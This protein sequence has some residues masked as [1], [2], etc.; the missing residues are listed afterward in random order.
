VLEYRAGPL[1]ILFVARRSL[2]NALAYGIPPAPLE[3]QGTTFAKLHTLGIMWTLLLD[4]LFLAYFLTSCY[5]QTSTEP[6]VQLGTTT[7]IGKALQPSN[8]DFFGGHRR[9]ILA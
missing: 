4:S 7:L 9:L 2:Y 8:L 6:H 5:S 3:G 1:D